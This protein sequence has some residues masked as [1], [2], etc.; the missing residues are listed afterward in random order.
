MTEQQPSKSKQAASIAMRIIFPFWSMKQTVQLAKQEAAKT[1]ENWATITEMSAEAK[2]ALLRGDG[3]GGTEREPM[4]FDEA[5]A[6]RKPG[7]M[8]VEQ[9]HIFFL[10]RKRA[11]LLAG[12]IFWLLG[13]LGIFSGCIDGSIKTIIQSLLSI[14]AASPLLFALA[15]SAQ[16]RM[17]QLETRR[18]SAAEHGG[19][20][21]FLKEN[22]NWLLKTLNPQYGKTNGARL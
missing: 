5:I 13:L 3:E 1:K 20:S 9:L 21:D 22:P 11:A 8:S 6:N 17:W 4:T 7:A 16:F 10:R 15:L 19:F 18:L 12:S 2:R 14:S